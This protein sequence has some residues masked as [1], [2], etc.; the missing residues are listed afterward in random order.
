MELFGIS[1]NPFLNIEVKASE[2]KMTMRRA[3][4]RRRE[5]TR[6]ST[7]TILSMNVLLGVF[8]R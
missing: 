2:T 5:M 4:T 8:P 3:I 1:Y 6:R 7:V